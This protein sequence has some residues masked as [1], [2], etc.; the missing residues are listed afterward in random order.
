MNI[1]KHPKDKI[2]LV[3]DEVDILEFLSYNLENA[4]YDVS[5]CE[6]GN[7]AIKLA[8]EIVPDLIVLDIMMPGLNGVSVCKKLRDIRDLDKTF[9]V[10]LTA[11]AEDYSQISALDV[12]G[13]DYI[14]KPIK[15]KVFLSRI[16]AVLRR[17]RIEQSARGDAQQ[18]SVGDL[19][20]DK[21]KIIVK[22]DGKKIDLVKKE[23]QLLY[24]LA[25]KPG[26]VFNRNEILSKV[27]GSDVI[28]GD[29]TIDVHVRK[30]REKLGAHYIKTVKGIG[31]KFDF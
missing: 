12:G 31:Y 15:P 27:W 17:R 18:I 29:R 13:D 16:E 14:I 9:I 28:V 6:D 10:F 21:E 24:L 25:Q 30:L 1:D 7:M 5:Q 8:K 11:K 20:I 22:Q 23:F 19:I 26:K 3:D 2:L 4:G